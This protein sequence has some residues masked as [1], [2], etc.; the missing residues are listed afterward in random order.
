MSFKMY[1]DSFLNAFLR[2]ESR[3]GIL[4]VMFLDSGG[5]FLKADKELNDL[6]NQL[7]QE[8]IKQAT[9]NKRVQWSFSPPAAPRFRNMLG[10]ADIN[11][12]ELVTTFVD[13]EG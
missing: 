3:K 6:A 12:E 13:A 8:R 11:D 1:T 7:D 2:M 9:A 10:N 5:N 4:K